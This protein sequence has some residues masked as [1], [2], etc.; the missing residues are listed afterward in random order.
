MA[1]GFAIHIGF[2]CLFTTFLLMIARV[3][4][5]GGLAMA[6]IHRLAESKENVT[7]HIDILSAQT[8]VSRFTQIYPNWR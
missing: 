7:L 1:F 6:R 8:G 2:N 3:N 5:P 4:Y